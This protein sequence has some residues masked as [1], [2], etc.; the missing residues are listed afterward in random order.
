MSDEPGRS[1]GR[2]GP[3]IAEL[4]ER[5]ARDSARLASHEAALGASQHVPQLRRVAIGAGTVAAIVLAFLTAFA[6]ANVTALAGLATAVPIWLA[7]LILAAFWV[8]VA[9]VLAAILRA[10]LRRGSTGIWIRLLGDDRATAVGELQASRDV[11]EHDLRMSLDR[12]GDAV[13]A[14]SAAQ[15]AD[16][17][18]PFAG[19]MGDALLDEAE[20]VLDD[21]PG[22][23]A[24]GQVVDIVLFPGRLGL[25]IAT[26]V[27]RGGS[28]SGG[29]PTDHRP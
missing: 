6:F 2:D 8:A 13:A 5:V 20:E 3:S 26:T 23:G 1:D 14:A 28:E 29:A 24:V 7:A 12:F 22:A 27:L 11:A 18:V 19:T 4:A 9:V 10:R 15:L 25:R 21:V 17:V 16:A